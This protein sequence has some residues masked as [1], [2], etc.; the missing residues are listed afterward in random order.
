[1][2]GLFYATPIIYPLEMVI[3]TNKTAGTVLLLSPVAQTIQ[4]ARYNA[5]SQQ[6][7]TTWSQVDDMLLQVIPPAIVVATVILAVVYFRKNQKY[8]AENV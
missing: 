5:I 4:D 3:S 1:M 7:L 6:V 8:F 2:Q